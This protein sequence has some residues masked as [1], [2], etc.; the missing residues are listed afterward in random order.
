M[1]ECQPSKLMIRVRFSLFTPNYLFHLSLQ[2]SFN[3]RILPCH[4]RDVGSIPI[5][6]SKSIKKQKNKK[7]KTIMSLY[8]RTINQIR[9]QFNSYCY[10]LWQVVIH[11]QSAFNNAYVGS[12][13]IL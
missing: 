7:G 10:P 12:V 8:T 1:V 13:A 2:V 9:Q 4:G 3:G 5:A 6:C 11:F